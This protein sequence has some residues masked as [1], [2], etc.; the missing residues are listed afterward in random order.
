MTLAAL[1]N[2]VTTSDELSS[3][4]LVQH[5]LSRQLSDQQ[6]VIRASD[7]LVKLFGSSSFILRRGR[8]L[9]LIGL[10]LLLPAKHQFAQLAMGT[11]GVATDWRD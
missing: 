11:S 9:G 10:N 2:R 3:A 1:I 6:R 5:Y 4:E 7:G 8:Q